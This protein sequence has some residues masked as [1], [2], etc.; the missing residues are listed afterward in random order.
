MS[1]HNAVMRRGILPFI[2]CRQARANPFAVF[3]GAI[4]VDTIHGMI[5]PCVAAIVITKTGFFYG[6][7]IIG[8]T[9]ALFD[10]GLK[11]CHGRL[12]FGHGKRLNSDGRSIIARNK[13]ARRHFNTTL[14]RR[15]AANTID[16]TQSINAFLAVDTKARAI[17]ML[18]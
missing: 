15:I 5:E 10:A 1:R 9:S 18:R 7:K 13:I 2:N 11:L 4:P 14:Q 12:S 16:E 6:C 3:I 17:V 8:R